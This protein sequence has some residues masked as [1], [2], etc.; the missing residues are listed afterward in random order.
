MKTVQSITQRKKVSPVASAKFTPKPVA[1]RQRRHLY[2]ACGLLLLL[3]AACY[4]NALFG[5]F[6]FDDKNIILENPLLRSIH[7]IPRML[8]ESYRPL[9]NLSHILELWL[10]GEH[11][12]GFHLTNLILH[13]INTLLVMLLIRRFTGDLRVA[14][15]AAMIFA[16]YPL[17]PDAVTYISGRRD[18]LFSLFYLAAFYQYLKYRRRRSPLAFALFVIFMVFSMLSKEMA[19]SLPLL[20][21]AWNFCEVWDAETVGWWRRLGKALRDTFNRDRWLYLALA[22]AALVFIWY[23]T[24]IQG[25]SKRAGVNG[26]DYWGGS[27][28]TNLLT[29]IKVHGWYLKQLLWPTP[30]IQYKG[31]F[32]IATTLW[33]WRV[34]VSLLAIGAALIAAFRL[35][36]RERLLAFAIFAYFIMLLPVSQ[37]IPHHELLADHYLYLPLMNYGLLV[38]L[39]LQKLARRSA[40]QKAVYAVAVAM[41]LTF[42]VMTVF[43]NRAY[44]DEVTLWEVNYREVPNS[45]RAASSLAKVN[46][47]INP[48][49]AKALYR[50]CIEIDPTYAPAYYSLAVLNKGLEEARET[51]AIIQQGLTL[52]DPRFARLSAEEVRLFRSQLITALALTKANRGD[53]EHAEPLMQE[54]LEIDAL[55]PFPYTLLANYYRDKDA[56]KAIDLLKRLVGVFASHDEPRRQLAT[57]LIENQ[58]Y[59]EA[60]A[61][62]ETLLARIPNDFFANYELSRIY[63][64]RQQC[65]RARAYLNAAQAAAYKATEV[66]D[67]QT[68]LA[69]LEQKCG[70]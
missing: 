5:D 55:N 50:R 14:T 20:V 70:R 47:N 16:V 63:L 44:K 21:F 23:A 39:L 18:L 68:L 3:V 49:K 54:A 12:F 32:D 35:L 43:R 29:A 59:D 61:Q 7:N 51:E 65:D 33:N 46:S 38:A 58:R 31:S 13:A 56:A 26:F 1:R 9:R 42:F 60:I 57:L 28:Y 34:I 40:W 64:E 53:W 24:F 19:V 37:I 2:I 30:I 8:V 67:C 22:L 27:F 11:P 69:T 41:G 52:Q 4:A 66:K 45:I 15:L 36:D 17:Q 25:G 10:W 6:V 62:L 48:N